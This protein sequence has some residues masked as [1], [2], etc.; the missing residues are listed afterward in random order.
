MKCLSVIVLYVVFWTRSTSESRSQSMKRMHIIIP[1]HPSPTNNSLCMR[2]R[3]PSTYANMWHYCIVSTLNELIDYDEDNLRRVGVA[4]SSI[5]ERVVLFQ[6]GIHYVNKS[7]QWS[8]KPALIL[9]ITGSSVDDVTIV[10]KASFNFQFSESENI[11]INNI[12]FK[13]CFGYYHRYR[14]AATLTFGLNVLRANITLSNIQ[15]TAQNCVGIMIH[16]TKYQNFRLMN[17]KLSTGSAGL[18][19]ANNLVDEVKTNNCRRTSPQNRRPS[20]PNRPSRPGRP[21]QCS[22][23]STYKIINHVNIMNTVF[24]TSCLILNTKQWT[25]QYTVTNATFAGCACSPILSIHGGKII[26]ICVLSPVRMVH[27]NWME[28][29]VGCVYL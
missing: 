25:Y 9:N 5:I 4:S 26:M 11:T 14:P 19:I 15:I 12:H 3:P 10:C 24:K 28:G 6:P 2:L 29:M 16:A 17:S 18:H 20:R 22:Y 7:G 8:G 1:S 21:G 27:I 23:S 13:N